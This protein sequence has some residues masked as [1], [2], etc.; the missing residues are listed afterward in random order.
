MALEVSS[1]RNGPKGGPWWNRMH[2]HLPPACRPTRRRMSVRLS[3]SQ[4][5]SLS[6]TH[7]PYK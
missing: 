2:P 5:L 1:E 4:F 3:T 6:R 7:F